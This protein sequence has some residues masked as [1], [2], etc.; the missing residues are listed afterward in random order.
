MIPPNVTLGPLTPL[1]DLGVRWL[2]DRDGRTV[3]VD[4]VDA[5]VVWKSKRQWE[6][7][8]KGL[9]YV[10]ARGVTPCWRSSNDH[11]RETA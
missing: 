10:T 1:S 3:F 9:R 2:T 7:K 6:R 4:G 8:P 11:L 5:G